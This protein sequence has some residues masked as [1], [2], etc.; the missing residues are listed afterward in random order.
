MNRMVK[1]EL[2]LNDKRGG[3]RCERIHDCKWHMKGINVRERKRDDEER[4]R[5]VRVRR[6]RV[7]GER[8]GGELN[9]GR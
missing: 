9:E 5:D 4:G 2:V 8:R 1:R 3:K 7:R 6:Q